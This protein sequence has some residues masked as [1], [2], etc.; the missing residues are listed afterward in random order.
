[1]S[2]NIKIGSEHVIARGCTVE[3][4]PWGSWQFPHAYYVDGRL[5]VSVHMSKDDINSY[6]NPQRWYESADQGEN[7][8]EIHMENEADC[9]FLCPNGDRIYFPPESAI[10]VKEY[11]MPDWGMRTPGYDVTK[12]AAEGT[13]P[14]PDGM[15]YWLD[16]TVIKAYKA[17]RLPDS[18]N[19]KEWNVLRIPKGKTECVKE[20]VSVEWPYMT[21]VIFTNTFDN[22]LKP[23]FP[24]GCLKTGPDGAIWVTS[25]S[26]EGH[27]NPVNG[28][29]SP[30][31]SAELFRS[32]DN[33]HSFV[34]W[35]HMEYDA[36]GHE[37]PYQNGGF[38]DSDIE[39][40]DDG[41]MVWFFRSAWAMYTGR[42]WDPMYMSRSTDGGHT[43]SKP[44]K[45]ADT[46]IY[47]RVCKL[48]CG[49]ALLCYAHPGIFVTACHD[50]KGLKWEAPMMIMTNQDRSGLSNHKIEHPNFHQWDGTCANPVLV[51]LDEYNALLVYSDFYYPDEKGIKR[52]TI[53]CRRITVEK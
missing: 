32:E 15:T 26:G 30:Y 44:V 12:Q 22:V 29:Y 38:S 25:Y 31:Y 13:L 33:G 48:G 2:M 41:S 8:K 34:Q 3:E 45:F 49:T 18:L 4:D 52:K 28:Q 9:G 11:D 51:G 53:L 10:S 17:E 46:G 42:E 50:G 21:K 16:G 19:K 35:A 23:L 43:W 36:D 6:G 37:F 24:K 39:F 20:K 1:M 40:M 27:I 47:P 7:W 5:F 14:L